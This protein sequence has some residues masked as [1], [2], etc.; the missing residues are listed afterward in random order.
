M[1]DVGHFLNSVAKLL[2]IKTKRYSD[3]IGE[4][5]NPVKLTDYQLDVLKVP[6]FV[7]NSLH[8]NGYHTK[9]DFEVAI[10]GKLYKFEKGKH[11]MFA[12]WD[13]LYI[14]FNEL[15]DVIEIIIES[16]QVKQFPKIS[17]TSMTYHD[18]Q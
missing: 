4:L 17:H 9:N 13:N 3:M 14:I 11:V 1:F 5:K 15:L 16:L 18:T 7:R 8:N 2:E 10:R 6:A 12:G